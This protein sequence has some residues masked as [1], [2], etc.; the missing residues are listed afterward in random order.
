MHNSRAQDPTV[1]ISLK[2]EGVGLFLVVTHAATA[3][4]VLRSVSA[5]IVA[6]LEPQRVLALMELTTYLGL[7]HHPRVSFIGPV[8]VDQQRFQHFISRLS[9]VPAGAPA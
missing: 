7:K 1:K 6:P 5:K 8:N 9:A 3:A 4:D 2:L